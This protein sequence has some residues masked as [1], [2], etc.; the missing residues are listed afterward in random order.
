MVAVIKSKIPNAACRR[1]LIYARILTFVQIGTHVLL[2]TKLFRAKLLTKYQ[3]FGMF[4][5]LNYCD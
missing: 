3:Y 1:C 5:G 4:L 2:L